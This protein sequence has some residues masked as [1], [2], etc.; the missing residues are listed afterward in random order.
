M[1]E[2]RRSTYVLAQRSQKGGSK[3]LSAHIRVYFG[4]NIVMKL[5]N[6]TVQRANLIFR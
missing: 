5:K 3:T 6:G 4:H 2:R 1:A